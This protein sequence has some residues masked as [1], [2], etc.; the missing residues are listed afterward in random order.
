[1]TDPIAESGQ[2]PLLALDRASLCINCLFDIRDVAAYLVR[3]G[4]EPR[5]MCSAVVKEQ[6][7]KYAQDLATIKL[8]KATGDIEIR[9]NDGGKD[10]IYQPTQREA[11][12]IR[13]SAKSVVWPEPKSLRRII[14]A[15]PM[16]KAAKAED[17]FEFRDSNDEIVMVQVR[18]EDDNGG[19][20]Y[21]PFT[22]YD[23][24]QWRCCEPDGLLPLFGAE[25][26][27]GHGIVF[28]HEGA[29]AAAH[30][31]RLVAAWTPADKR[32]LAEHPWGRELANSAHV[33]WIGGAWSPSRTDWSVL[34]KA[35]VK[36]VFIVAD[37]DD[38]GR[39]AIPAI[40]HQLRLPT[41]A[42]QFTDEF[43][44]SFDLADKFPDKMRSKD[45]RYIGPA[46][47]ALL[48][49][50]T[51]ATDVLHHPKGGRP[52]HI[53]RSHF[54]ELWVYAD[55]PEL[56][57]CKVEPRIIRSADNLSK[58]LVKYSDSANTSR[59]LLKSCEQ[60]ATIAYAPDKKTGTV[61]VRGQ[62][63]FNVYRPSDI[64]PLDRPLNE[65]EAAPWVEF[66]EYLFPDKNERPHVGRWCAT[67]IAKPETCIHYGLLLVSTTQ[68]VGKNI[69]ASQVLGPLLGD[70]NVGYPS[71]HDVSESQFNDWYA[72]KR[73]AVVGEIYQGQ[74]WKAYNRLKGV[75][76]DKECEVNKKH[77][78]KYRTD[79]WCHVIACSNSEECLKMEDT[80]R[81][82][83][84][85]KI[86]ET[87][88]PRQ[89]FDYFINWLASGGLSVVARW[90]KDYDDFVKTGDR[91]P[92]TK[93]KQVMIEES[94]PEEMRW[95]REY[96][97]ERI[98][99]GDSFVIST[100]VALAF[101]EKHIRKTIYSKKRA[102]GVAM[103]KA[104]MLQFSTPD[105]RE[106]TLKYLREQHRLFLSP[107]GQKE[108]EDLEADSEQLKSW[109]REK[110]QETDT[111]L[112]N[113]G[114]F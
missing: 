47:Q 70:H 63:A 10:S 57:V 28:I 113:T 3:I 85:P 97:A 34:A 107:K 17:I 1:M 96:C 80:D 6:H 41:F 65:N 79:N 74:S 76:T 37:N 11:E 58:K 61:S 111:E 43:P 82:W 78:A 106:Y 52:T 35:G 55:E 23:D 51:W 60:V 109:L 5:S 32:A 89:K 25:G 88:W 49:P 81:R 91:P 72:H 44:V 83:F 8:D 27:A 38:A 16:M 19:K 33:G 94:E 13:E 68:G 87:P 92:M 98:E 50:A 36:N 39:R 66:L 42:I 110:L 99:I 64:K 48:E 90:A 67:L 73:L 40:A 15:L 102:F 46:F 77:Q 62:R 105:G 45:N 53:L 14:N 108:I 24:D 86:T 75:I 54:A 7:G 95:V 12:D 112:N 26:L 29:K 56:F 93:R 104:G 9:C 21:I 69:F 71:E 114:P 31:R 4:A 59:L 2:S 22:Y 103:Q 84:Y 101:A 100:S 20:S 30:M 18:V